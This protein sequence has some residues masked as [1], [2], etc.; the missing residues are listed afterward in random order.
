MTNEELVVAIQ[1]GQTEL[2]QTLWEQNLRFVQARARAWV[3]AFENKAFFDAADLVQQGW[4]AM[5]TAVKYFDPNR[6]VKYMTLFSLCL[7]GEFQ[8]VIGL[9][10]S[11]RDVL[12]FASLS[13]DSPAF[14]GD[15]DSVTV[16]DMLPDPD[17]ERAF[18][19]AEDRMT[20]EH[21]RE[22]LDNVASDV[23]DEKHRAVY[24]GLLME[25]RCSDMARDD[26]VTRAR[27]QQRKESV[28]EALR[29]DPR[30]LQLWLDVTGSGETVEEIAAR[31][32]ATPGVN[33]FN[34]SGS[35][36]VERAVERIIRNEQQKP[37]KIT[38]LKTELAG[39]LHEAREADH[40]RRQHIQR[41]QMM[42]DLAAL[43]QM[44][45]EAGMQ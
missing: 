21:L 22:T 30:I 43:D 4:F 38:M 17:A 31:Y 44:R 28:F 36:S 8:R 42:S 33:S 39:K 19:D 3:R 20:N 40:K 15:A 18:A 35:S 11:K 23:L 41:Q 12:L 1:N 45:M 13:L 10:S 34:H 16:A 7:K 27:M 32:A 6:E 2:M 26:D 37:L 24:E 5:L 25:L 14:P 9:H 29:S